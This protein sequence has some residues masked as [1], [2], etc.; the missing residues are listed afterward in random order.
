MKKTFFKDLTELPETFIEDWCVRFS[1]LP[2]RPLSKENSGMLIRLFWMPEESEQ[3]MFEEL[4]KNDWVFSGMVKRATHRLSAKF[5]IKA[6]LWL[7][8][9][10]ENIG[11][12]VMLLYYA[13]YIAKKNN[14]KHVTFSFINTHVFPIG[15]PSEADLQSLWDLQKVEIGGV[16]EDNAIDIVK[17]SKSIQF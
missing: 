1:K 6:I 9:N 11:T 3:A 14:T 16:S 13:Q 7:K 2:T 10:A 5:D 12:A 15:F 4:L 17:A 8:I